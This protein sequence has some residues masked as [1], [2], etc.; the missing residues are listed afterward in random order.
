MEHGKHKMR[1]GHMMSNK[2]MKKNMGKKGG[3]PKGKGKKG[4]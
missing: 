2:V 1:N 4:Y 3:K